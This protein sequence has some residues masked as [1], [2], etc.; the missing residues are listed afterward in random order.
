[1]H[2]LL[3]SSKQIVLLIVSWIPVLAGVA[4]IHTIIA[5]ASFR[6]ALILLG[7]VML[8]EMFLF[9]SVW[10]ICKSTPLEAKNLVTFFIRHIITIVVM[11]AIW[12]HV[13]ML[14]SEVL[15]M[16]YK[17]T[18]WSTQF[19][20]IF[21]VL[22]IVGFFVYF[23]SAMLSYLLLALE[24][25]RVVEQQA[26]Q[27]QL[28][29][30]QAELR[31]LRAT[32][33]PHFLFNSLTALG[34]LTRTSAEKAQIVCQQL[35]EFL[36]YSLTFSN[37]DFV[38]IDEELK[39]IDNYLGVEKIRMGRRLQTSFSIDETVLQEKV[40]SFS[41]QPLIEN[42]IKHGIEPNLEGGTITLNI[43][44]AEEHIFINISNPKSQNKPKI[45]ST[46]HGLSN[47]KSRLKKIYEDDAK[48]LVHDGEMAFSV[49]LYLP[50]L[51]NPN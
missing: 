27:N 18:E 9:I 16:V 11:N 46:G 42:A 38:T 35:A 48:I 32:I 6:E 22:M 12:L 36:R 43:Q 10:Y 30:S 15:N 25:T 33:H 5:S 29:A 8:L 21:P 2:P 40:L 19:D 28:K 1:M 7:P 31:F 37:K 4:F 20:K 47:L 50:K 41:L 26:L 3:K 23:L 39:H 34:T 44:N 13:A 17:S 45:E 49:K 51:T 24:Q 14:Y